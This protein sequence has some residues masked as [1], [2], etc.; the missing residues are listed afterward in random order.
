MSTDE[1]ALHLPSHKPQMLQEISG[2]A[3]DGLRKFA[4]PIGRRLLPSLRPTRAVVS[5]SGPLRAV[6]LSRDKW[7]GG[8][9]NKW[10]A[11][12]VPLKEA[13]FLRSARPEQW[14]ALRERVLY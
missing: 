14:G 1:I 8:S 3:L 2:A 5:E 4:G 11:L 10:T 7:P 6:H 13:C 12:V 9:V